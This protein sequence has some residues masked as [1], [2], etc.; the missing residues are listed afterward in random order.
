MLP[1]YI[2][3]IICL[4]VVLFSEPLVCLLLFFSE[5][6]VYLLFCSVNH[7]FVFCF[8]QRAIY[9]FLFCSA[10]YLFVCCFVQRAICLFVVLFRDL[11]VCLLFCSVSH[12]FVCCFVH[13]AIWSITAGERAHAGHSFWSFRAQNLPSEKICKYS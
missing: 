6:S 9:V 2:V 8:V 1:L 5:P 10:S 12:L 11:S 13:R 4:F 7:L 3:Y